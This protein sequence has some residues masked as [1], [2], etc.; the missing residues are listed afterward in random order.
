LTKPV[1]FVD[2][3]LAAAAIERVRAYLRAAETATPWQPGVVVR[4]L[5]RDLSI[6]ESALA[7]VLALAADDGR[8]AYRAG[9]YATPEFQPQLTPE[10]RSFFDARF[11]AGAGAPNVPV[12]HDELVAAMRSCAIAG[13]HVAFETLLA[14]GALVKI[15]DDV[16]RGEQI[17]EIRTKLEAALRRD[18][19]LT[20]A[21]FRDLAGTSR[22]FAVPLLE[23]FDATGVTIRSGDVR[24]LR[25]VPPRR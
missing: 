16:Y 14:G 6:P 15:G 4:T 10:Q 22:K 20:M 8:L 23:W 25:I 9:Y 3:A 18:K 24:V 11:A 21:A 19:Q 12:P 5:G 2:G 13:I 7:R 17:A 1:A